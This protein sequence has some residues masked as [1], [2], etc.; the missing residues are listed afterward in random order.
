MIG[1]PSELLSFL[2]QKDRDDGSD[3]EGQN[4]LKKMGYFGK[5]IL[6]INQDFKTDASGKD[7]GFRFLYFE[8]QNSCPEQEEDDDGDEE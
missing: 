5:P 4:P 7:L 2:D 1:L 6:T 8:T 3:Y